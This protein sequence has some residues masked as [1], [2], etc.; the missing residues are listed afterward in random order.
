[1]L[2]YCLIAALGTTFASLAP[3][4]DAKAA[5]ESAVKAM[6]GDNLGSIRYT[7]TGLNYAFGQSYGPGTPYPKFN[8][9]TYGKTFDFDAAAASQ[10]MVRTQAENPPRGGGQQPM[11]GENTQTVTLGEKLPWETKYELYTN[12]LSFLKGAIANNA[13][14]TAK[15]VSGKKYNIVS[16]TVDKK[17]KVD[18]YLNDQ[19]MVEKVETMIDTPVLGDTPIVA[20]FSDYKDFNGVKFPAKI[21]ETEGGFPIYDLSITDIKRNVIAGVVPPPAPMENK[22]VVDEQLIAPDVYYF[23]GGTHHSVVIGFNDYT[24][25]IEGPLDDDRSQAVISEVKKLFFNKPIRYLVNTH[26]HFDHLGGVRAYAA[27]GATI[28]TYQGNKAYYEKMLAMP[29]TLNPDKFAQAKPAKKVVVEPVAEKRV[30]MDS[31]H[32]VDLY[33]IQNSGH[34]ETMLIAYLPKDKVLIEAD[35]YTAPV[36]DPAAPPPDPKAPAPPI[37]PYTVSLVDNLERLKLY[38]EKIFGLH[39]REATKEELMKAAGKPMPEQAKK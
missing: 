20:T 3:A 6:G 29:H 18:G 22:P 19:N 5:L 9:K 35:L 25:V 2:K 23:T 39:G 1:M 12:P 15:T 32:E 10:K 21:V 17:Y 13:T 36:I 26:A 14:L 7:A 8:I 4:Q 28:V 24:M 37:S 11:N 33:H 38:P 34:S 31:A 30:F 16:F 27:E